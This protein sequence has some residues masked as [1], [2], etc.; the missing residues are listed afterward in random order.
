MLADNEQEDIHVIVPMRNLLGDLDPMESWLAEAKMCNFRVIVL[1]DGSTDLTLSKLQALKMSLDFE[2]LQ[3][4]SDNFGGPGPARNAGLKLVKSGW[5]IFWDSD[6][7]PNVLETL[8]MV[9]KTEEEGL[10]VAIGNWA[11]NKSSKL[12]KNLSGSTQFTDTKPLSAF[13]NPG[14]WRWAFKREYIG[15]TEFPDIRMGEDQLFLLGLN[16]KFKS[17]YR[18]PRVVYIYNQVSPNQLTGNLKTVLEGRRMGKFVFSI[19][20]INR[21]HSAYS[22]TLAAKILI[23]S[24]KLW[25]KSGRQ[26][27]S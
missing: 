26:E 4:V 19:M 8:Q 7:Y 14:L 9:R 3:I 20:R 1:D 16:V 15:E 25:V 13:L 18:H 11:T 21:A 23:L 12:N 2:S 24:A 22:I 5:V 6:D 10:N 17:V 27:L